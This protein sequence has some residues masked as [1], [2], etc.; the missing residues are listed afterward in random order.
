MDKK[1]FALNEDFS[2]FTIE[3]FDLQDIESADGCSLF[4]K[5]AGI[6]FASLISL[7]MATY[8]F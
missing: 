1:V 2:S 8:L 6:K 7:L 3:Q 5:W 4:M